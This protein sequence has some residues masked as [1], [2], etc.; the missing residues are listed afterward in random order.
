MGSVQFQSRAWDFAERAA[1]NQ[2]WT[3]GL[4]GVGQWG[5]VGPGLDRNFVSAARARVAAAVAGSPRVSV[6]SS[7]VPNAVSRLNP[8]PAS[9]ADI[10]SNQVGTIGEEL[11]RVALEAV[12]TDSVQRATI[13]VR[14]TS[15]EV[16][17]VVPDFLRVVDV[18][19]DNGLAR[20]DI[21]EV[22][23]SRVSQ[24]GIGELTDNQAVFLGALIQGN[25]ADLTRSPTLTTF[26]AGLD[27]APTAFTIDGFNLQSFLLF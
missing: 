24:P 6:S 19:L 14:L 13:T 21:D 20:L 3:V 22:K 23:A 11:H 15:G 17:D 2:Q 12:G 25:I 10:P 4:D 1:N 16:F 9:V 5:R 7:S 8:S 26:L 18:D 27:G